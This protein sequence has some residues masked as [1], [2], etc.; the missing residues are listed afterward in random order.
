MP[1]TPPLDGPLQPIHC[2]VV[3]LLELPVLVLQLCQGLPARGTVCASL[4]AMPQVLHAQG[5]IQD[6]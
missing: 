1:R 6:M 2:C 3:S 4:Y 5:F